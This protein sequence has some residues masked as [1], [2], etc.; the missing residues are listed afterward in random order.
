MLHGIHALAPSV[1]LL[2]LLLQ[3]LLE[4]R[5]RGIVA[6]MGV[7]ER[8]QLL[9]QVVVVAACLPFGVA[10]E[11]V[12]SVGRHLQG[13]QQFGV[14][15]GDVVAVEAIEIGELVAARGEQVFPQV[16][17]GDRAARHGGFDQ[18]D[19]G[20]GSLQ[21]G[22]LQHFAFRAFYVDFEEVDVPPWRVLLQQGIEGLHGDG[23]CVDLAAA[24][25]VGVC[26]GGVQRGQAGF[27]DVV[28]GHRPGAAGDCDLHIRVAWPIGLE[29]AVPVG[30]GFD[31][32]PVPALFVEPA[33][34][35]ID[36]GVVGAD[37]HVV[38]GAHMLQGPPEHDVF[39]VLRVGN[40][41]HGRAMCRVG[42]NQLLPSKWGWRRLTTVNRS[43]RSRHS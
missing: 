29:L 17:V 32:E 22:A 2:L 31:V 27:G 8:C 7:A 35:R 21:T 4:L 9:A 43:A 42:G 39:K 16:V 13:G 23:D 18:D 14:L 41:G 12:E 5:H 34:D 10:H 3:A 19:P 28:E 6:L 30:H 40:D 1:H 15:L 25:A 38:A 26:N 36:H 33:G 37:V 11:A 20:P 24:L